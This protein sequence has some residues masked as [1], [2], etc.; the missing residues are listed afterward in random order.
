MRNDTIS[1]AWK[2]KSKLNEN[3]GVMTIL[4]FSDFVIEGA[5][6]KDSGHWCLKK[7]SNN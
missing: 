5:I 7:Q 4:W 6:S 2:Y 3:K 1:K